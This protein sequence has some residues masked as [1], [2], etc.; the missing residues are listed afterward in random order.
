MKAILKYTTTVLLAGTLVACAATPNVQEMNQLSKSELM[1]VLSGNTLQLPTD[2]GQWTELFSK[3][4]ATS[5]ATAVGS[6]FNEVVTGVNKI[7]DGGEVCSIY[8]GPYKWSKPE[9]EYCGTFH[10]NAQGQFFTKVTQN[11]RRPEIV[12]KVRSFTIE[13]GNP[14]DLR[15]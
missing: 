5:D 9:W 12:G 4:L 2:W 3:D 10:T 6:G 15:S 13:K 7:S 11:N 1:E 14:N 8:E